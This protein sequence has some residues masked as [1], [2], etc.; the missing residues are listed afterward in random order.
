MCLSGEIAILSRW[1]IQSEYQDCYPRSVQ[2]LRNRLSRQIIRTSIGKRISYFSQ[3]YDP[4]RRTVHMF[5]WSIE[6]LPT[7]EAT[8]DS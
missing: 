3:D 8:V 5:S 4:D 1:G 2:K 7:G 6:A